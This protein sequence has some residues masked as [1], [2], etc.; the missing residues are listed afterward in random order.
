M[1]ADDKKKIKDLSS[2]IRGKNV[3][4]LSESLEVLRNVPISKL[5]YL[6]LEEPVWVLL[7]SLALN[8]VMESASK[9]GAKYVAAQSFGRIDNANGVE[10]I[11]V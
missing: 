1:S 8:S 2:E 6:K 11:S 5:D 3:L 7:T 9:L 10:L 4:V